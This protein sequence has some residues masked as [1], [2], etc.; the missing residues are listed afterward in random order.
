MEGKGGSIPESSD[1]N[2]GVGI[3]CPALKSG[4]NGKPGGGGGGGGPPNPP[5]S[6]T[7]G[8]GMDGER[9]GGCSIRERSSLL[10]I[11]TPSA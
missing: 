2:G 1:M 7:G 11:P 10:A 8:G 9:R 3:K 6:I 5:R 4:S